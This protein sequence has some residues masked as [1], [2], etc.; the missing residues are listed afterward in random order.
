MK[1]KKRAGVSF[2]TGI[3]LAALL[4]WGCSNTFVITKD[5][6]SYF[7]GSNREGFQKMLCESGDSENHTR[8]YTTAF[9]NTGRA[10]QIQLRGN[11]TLKRQGQ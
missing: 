8:R 2:L 9:K 4:S 3:L 5:G 1:D 6:K 7:F 11:G 10:L